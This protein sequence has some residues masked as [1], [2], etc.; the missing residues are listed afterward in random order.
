MKNRPIKGTV[1][2][3]KL[4]I[5]WVRAK[6]KFPE[7]YWPDHAIGTVASFLLMGTILVFIYFNGYQ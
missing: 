2:T 5:N 1:H 6:K 4:Y 3:L 7:L